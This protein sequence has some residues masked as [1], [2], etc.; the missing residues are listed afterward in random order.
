MNSGNTVTAAT[1]GV[2]LGGTLLAQITENPAV[3]QGSVILSVIGLLAL[4]ANLYVQD[5]EK[6]RV[7]EDVYKDREYLRKRVEKL[8][9]ALEIYERLLP[10][11][12]K[13]ALVPVRAEI[14]AFKSP[15][16]DEEPSQS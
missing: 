15:T 9:A 6:K 4:V 3:A 16:Q 13:I 12:S 10:P 11:D 5:R 7:H 2:S 8:Q 14:D 1:A